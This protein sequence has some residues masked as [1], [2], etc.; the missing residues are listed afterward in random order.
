MYDVKNFD[1]EAIFAEAAEK[2]ERYKDENHQ[3]YQSTLIGV[4][5][6]YIQML[7]EEAK[8]LECEHCNHRLLEELNQQDQQ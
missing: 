5:K 8:R 6:A 3:S 4:Y 2:A 1:H 7:C